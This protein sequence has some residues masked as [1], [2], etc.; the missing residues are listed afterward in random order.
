MFVF[1]FSFSVV[2]AAPPGTVKLRLSVPLVR[3]GYARAVSRT[4]QS[5]KVNQHSCGRMNQ[6]HHRLQLRFCRIA[7]RPENS[8]STVSTGNGVA[9][10]EERACQKQASGRF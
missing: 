4:T 6:S 5:I 7:D 9:R 3:L 10:Y 1:K 8:W 2:R